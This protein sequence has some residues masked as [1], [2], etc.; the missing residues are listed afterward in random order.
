MPD[1]FSQTPRNPSPFNFPN[2][3]ASGSISQA[4]ES[5]GSRSILNDPAE[6]Q[7]L[8]TDSIQSEIQ[9]RNERIRKFYEEL[10]NQTQGIKYRDPHTSSIEKQIAHIKS[11]NGYAR[12]TRFYFEVEGLFWTVNDRLVRN[13]Q[14]MSLPGRALQ[15]QPARKS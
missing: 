5:L 10:E 6:L 13:C 14:S 3:V 7:V 9:R 11:I 1:F 2:D 4:R 12:P 15:S 8:N